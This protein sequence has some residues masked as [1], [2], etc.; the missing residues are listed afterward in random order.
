MVIGGQADAYGC[1]RMELDGQPLQQQKG[2][3]VVE[4]SR[5]ALP[6]GVFVLLWAKKVPTGTRTKQEKRMKDDGSQALVKIEQTE[7]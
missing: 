2:F 4:D 3:N 6:S 7:Q 1:E 5:N